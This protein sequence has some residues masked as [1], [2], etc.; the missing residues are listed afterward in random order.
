MNADRL[1]FCHIDV[2]VYQS[3]HDACSF[4]WPRLSPGGVVVFDDYGFLGCE[5]VTEYVDS[6]R[7]RTDCTVVGNANGH[8]VV[9]KS[10]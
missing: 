2:D 10:H 1:S 6:L 9:I 5:G 4:V 7:S 3:A 8:G